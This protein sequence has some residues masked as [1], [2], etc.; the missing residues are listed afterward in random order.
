MSSILD[1]LLAQKPPA[2][3][4]AVLLSFLKSA[5]GGEFDDPGQVIP[6]RWREMDPARRQA[7]FLDLFSTWQKAGA[8][9]TEPVVLVAEPSLAAMMFYGLTRVTPE[10]PLREM[11]SFSTC[12]SDPRQS[13]SAVTATWPSS[14]DAAADPCPG[15]TLVVNTTREPAADAERPRTEYAAAMIQSIVEKGWAEVDWRLETVAALK[16]RKPEHLDTVI[17]AEKLVQSALQTG[18][19]ANQT[20]RKSEA[21][22]HCVRRVLGRELTRQ[23]D[24]VAALANVVGKPAHLS[25]VDLLA[26]LPKEAFPRA[27]LDHLLK[28]VPEEK[29]EVLLKMAGVGL[30]DKLQA[31][32][33]YV[34]AHGKLPPKCEFL[35]DE[36]IK[37]AKTDDLKKMGLMPHVLT[38]LD[39]EPLAKFLK[40]Q[41]TSRAMN[42]VLGLLRLCQK[43]ALKA[44]HVTPVVEALDEA[45]LLNLLKTQGTKFVEEYPGEEPAL[46]R[47]LGQFARSLATKPAEFKERLEWVVAGQHLMEDRDQQATLAWSNCRNAILAVGRLQEGDS[48]ASEQAW[49]NRLSAACRDLAKE[50]DEAIGYGLEGNEDLPKRKVECLEKIAKEVLGKPM[51]P[52]GKP[53]NDF[54]WQKIA[55]R[56]QSH[57]WQVE[58][59]LSKETIKAEAAGKK[60]EKGPKKLPGKEPAKE[61]PKKPAV[62]KDEGKDG[63]EAPKRLS[64]ESKSLAETSKWLNYIIVGV[65]VLVMIGVVWWLVNMLMGA[66]SGKR[67]KDRRRKT[68]KSEKSEDG[69]SERK[70]RENPTALLPVPSPRLEQPCD[71]WRPW[72]WV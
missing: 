9:R 35:W 51:L 45:A 36:W 1:D 48:T 28:T 50:A 31:L 8:E 7:W 70:R 40:D 39:K 47:R 25:I 21:L 27:A 72:N 69:K 46:G 59:V 5:A 65:I 37:G 38:R 56:F 22:T 33:R 67:S 17:G 2:V 49:L 18:G 42:A 55:G 10:G 23:A 24:P 4:D 71:D 44:S 13:K 29:Y 3:S 6:S 16:I 54:F 64:G 19:F 62:K 11:L 53:E 12:E 58:G 61:P 57:Q 66:S 63:K 15:C 60:E 52:R 26:G 20:W 43:K 41:P 32:L 14:A 34:E 30:G 68:E